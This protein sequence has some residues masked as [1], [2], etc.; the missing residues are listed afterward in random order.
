MR[1][2]HIFI[3]SP[4]DVSR[5]R[6]LTRSVVDEIN[7]VT[8]KLLGTRFDV[9]TWED[10]LTSGIGEPQKKINREI[11]DRY[12]PSLVLMIGIIGQRFGSP[13]STHDSGTLEEFEWALDNH[14]KT[15]WPEIKWFFKK[16][17]SLNVVTSTQARM[18]ADQLE[19]IEKFKSRL[20]TIG[21]SQAYYHEF[22]EDEFESLLRKDLA[23]WINDPRRPWVQSSKLSLHKEPEGT[24]SLHI[25]LVFA[26]HQRQSPEELE[27]P[28]LD[29]LYEFHFDGIKAKTILEWK[30]KFN[31]MR[32]PQAILRAWLAVLPDELGN[33]MRRLSQ[34]GYV[35]TDASP[36]VLPFSRHS[37]AT[38]DKG[39]RQ[40]QFESFLQSK[41]GH[42]ICVN[43]VIDGDNDVML[44]KRGKFTGDVFEIDD[45]GGLLFALSPPKRALCYRLSK[46]GILHFEYL[47]RTRTD[48]RHVRL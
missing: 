27:Y 19:L 21:P 29:S 47:R 23:E 18:A 4:S 11:L 36:I 37:T 13:T 9:V 22:E 46:S 39:K 32:V 25:G 40:D 14:E 24:S 44:A 28:I 31:L 34:L 16:T 10:H 2:Y 45:P 12:G 15:G 6:E 35:E 8:T 48:G 17:R 26:N 42:Q 41:H 3:A 5:E 7:I 1:Q 38:N 30:N 43:V 20:K 33:A